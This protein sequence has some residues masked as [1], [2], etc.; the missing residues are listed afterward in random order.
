VKQFGEVI[1]LYV[2]PIKSCAGIALEHAPLDA[3]GIIHD[4][5]WMIVSDDEEERG[6]FLSQRELPQMATIQ[7]RLTDDALL[8][9]APHMPELRISLT[10]RSDA[11]AVPVIVWDD[12]CLAHDEG[13]EAADWLRRCLGVPARLVRMVDGFVRPVDPRYAGSGAQTGFSDGFPV[14]IIA[15]ASLDDLNARL[16]ARGK[17]SVPMERFRPNIVVGGCAPF[18]E[19]EWQRIHIG[20]LSF[21][22]VKPCKRCAIT[23]VDPFSGTIPDHEE[24]LATLATYRRG[25]HG[26]VIFGQNAIHRV[27][28]ILTL[29][30]DITD[31]TTS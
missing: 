14:L 13:D 15:Q 20:G 6:L 30:A 16:V 5:R 23:T 31:D 22:V 28:G 3:R 21:D 7:P 25:P 17:A 12:A 26:G 24:P 29:G 8:V 11:Q 27:K 1:G 10:E 9:S 19:D 2:Y 4:R 18:A